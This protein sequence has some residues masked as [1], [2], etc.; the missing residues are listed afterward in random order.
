MPAHGT[1]PV[2]IAVCVLIPIG[3]GMAAVVVSVWPR[4]EEDWEEGRSVEGEGKD[5]GRGPN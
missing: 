5:E 3:T 4:G 2:R 1:G